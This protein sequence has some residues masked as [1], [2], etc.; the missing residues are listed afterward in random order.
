[1]SDFVVT[2]GKVGVRS[3]AKLSTLTVEAKPSF[4]L[5]GT[6]AKS[7]ASSTLAGTGT[8]FISE[9]GIGDRLLVPGGTGE[10]RIVTAIASDTSL[11]VNSDFENTASGQTATCFPGVA[12]FER[13]DHTSPVLIS[14]QGNLYVNTVVPVTTSRP[15]PLVH[16]HATTVGEV[17]PY[18]LVFT[19]ESS[20]PAE[21]MG[22]KQ[23]GPGLLLFNKIADS[24]ESEIFGVGDDTMLYNVG[25]LVSAT[26]VDANYTLQRI[27][28]VVF[29]DAGVSGVTISLPD[30]NDEGRREWCVIKVAG[31]GDVTVSP[32]G[33]NTINGVN[34][35]KTISTQW[36][37]LRLFGLVAERNGNGVGW[38]ATAMP[39]A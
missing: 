38:V 13:S 35:S 26:V 33:S 34:A 29:V 24:G 23:E 17:E 9:V 19:E 6:V 39:A 5:S 12:R 37:G 30:V 8:L 21:G 1:M 20:F 32:D 4:T 31:A 36:S 15:G 16:I 28:F 25:H 10:T 27:D 3:G 11:T 14:D 2:D 18:S 22:I 7:A